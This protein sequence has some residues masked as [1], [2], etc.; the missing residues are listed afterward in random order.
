MGID[1]TKFVRLRSGIFYTLNKLAEN[2][3]CYGEREQLVKKA[4]ELLEVEEGEIEVTLDEMLRTKDVIQEEEAI[5]LPPYYFS[6]SG[7]AKRLLE[8]LLT[9]RKSVIDTEKTLEKVVSQ[10]QITYD[11]IQLEAVRTAISSKVMI[12]TGGIRDRKN[13]YHTGYYICL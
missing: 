2:G 10:S 12:L 1:K 3:H 11:E 5:Y 13:H 4:K 9:G 8:L 6:E 7:C